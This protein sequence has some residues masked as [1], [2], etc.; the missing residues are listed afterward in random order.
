ME[1]KH[2][3]TSAT[4]HAITCFLALLVSV[5]GPTI[6]TVSA[7]HS[8]LSVNALARVGTTPV[9]L[10]TRIDIYIN[11]LSLC[12][13]QTPA[14]RHYRVVHSYQSLRTA[15]LS[16][17]TEISHPS[18]RWKSALHLKFCRCA[19]HINV[20]TKDRNDKPSSQALMCGVIPKAKWYR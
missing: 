11:I 1:N 16:F 20:I 14:K 6:R 17:V 9:I 19:W 7:H 3:N 8:V 10:R 4:V 5:V 12:Y 2:T 18:L 13:W 15:I